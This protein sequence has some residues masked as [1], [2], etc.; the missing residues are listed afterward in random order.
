MSVVY[1]TSWYEEKNQARRKELISCLEQVVNSGEVDHVHLLAEAE[2]PFRHAKMSYRL[3]D[4]RPTYNDFFEEANSICENDDVI[5]LAN[6]DIYPSVGTRHKLLGIDSH[7]CYALARWDEKPSG[8]AKLFDRVDSQDVWVFRYPVK[9]VQGD[10]PVGIPGCDNRIAHELQE[11]G[12]K[13]LNPSRSVKFIHRHHSNVHTYKV[14]VHSISPPY[15]RVTPTHLVLKSCTTDLEITGVLHV[16][17]DQPPLERAFAR[18]YKDYHFIRWT[19]YQKNI[20]ALHKEIYTQYLTGKYRLIFFHV[21]TAGVITPELIQTMRNSEVVYNPQFIN[22]T[23]DV[24]APLPEWYIKLGAEVTMTLFSNDTDA[25]QARAKGIRAEYLQIGFDQHLFTPAPARSVWP[26]IVFLGNHYHKLFPLSDLR[27]EMV[28]KL[29]AR[30]GHRFGCYGGNWDKLS[31]GNLMNNSDAEVDCLRGCKIAIN[32]SH[33]D[34]ERYSSDRI[35]RI[36]GTGAFCLTK[37]YPRMEEDF[38]PGTHVGVWEDIDDLIDKIDH[39]LGSTEDRE[40]IARNGSKEAHCCHTW[41]V[42]IQQLKRF[43]NEKR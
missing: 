34:Y 22:W 25:K 4:K 21:Q 3:V 11:A 36:L 15:L 1:L 7:E 28:Q 16:G 39:F 42:R 6:T 43:L 20:P 24:R 31:Q 33:F 37:R 17:F 32:L 9:P 10:F 38:I 26:E 12:Y 23:G 5:A 27:M 13:V 35:F 18:E 41:D 19:D 30:Y 14:G 40:A 2:P 8:D 29:H